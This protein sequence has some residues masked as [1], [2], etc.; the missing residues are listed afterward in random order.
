MPDF[1]V[2]LN[3]EEIAFVKAQPRGWLR[4]LVQV[5]M[6]SFEEAPLVGKRSEWLIADEVLADAAAPSK[7]VVKRLAAQSGSR[8]AKSQAKAKASGRG[9]CKSCGA[10][11]AFHGQK[12]CTVCQAKA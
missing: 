11:L 3:A 6:E 10:P 9:V 5:Q 8:L 7:S 4:R 1:A 12:S 2:Y